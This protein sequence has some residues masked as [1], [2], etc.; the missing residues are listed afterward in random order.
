MWELASVTAIRRGW[1]VALVAVGAV[2]LV[3]TYVVAVTTEW[4]PPG[5]AQHQAYEA[6]NRRVVL[7]TGEQPEFADVAHQHQDGTG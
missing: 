3:A 2:G 5:T 4:G 1:P 6:H 7:S